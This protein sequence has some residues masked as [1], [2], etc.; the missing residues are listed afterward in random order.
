MSQAKERL[1]ILWISHLIPYPP[2]GGVLMRSNFLAT[3]LARH[4]Q[5]DLLALNQ[6]GLMGAYFPSQEEGI[7]KA[8][9]ALEPSFGRI[10]FCA[11]SVPA[12]SRAKAW[13]AG[14]SLFT[15]LPYSIACLTDPELEKAIEGRIRRQDYDVVHF[16]TI[17]LAQYRHLAGDLPTVL[18]HHNVES[19]MMLRRA[20]KEPNPVKKLYFYQE[21]YRLRRYERELAPQFDG[22]ITCSEVDSERLHELV[23]GLNIKCIPNAVRV[24]DHQPQN[25]PQPGET[26]DLLFIGG[27]DWYPNRDAVMHLAEEI[28]PRL[29]EHLEG[30]VHIIGKN[31]PA[32]LTGMAAE[33]P[34]FHIHG[35]VDDIEEV[36]RRSLI[37][38]CP[39]RDGGGTKLKVLD[40]MAHGM[41]VVGYPETFEGLEVT[42][43]QDCLLCTTPEQFSRRVLELQREPERARLIG[44][45][46]RRL[47]EEKYE[48][49]KVG[50]ALADYYRQVA[51]KQAPVRE[52]ASQL[53]Q[54]RAAANGR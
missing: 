5:V 40:A 14:K 29:A 13:L 54:W 53:A 30:D 24:A 11:S 28:M 51:A 33:F 23:Q 3:E 18:D 9:A 22:H 4:H 8:R 46:A 45:R 2:K 50:A 16:D 6:P 44:E 25:N 38:V 34:R 31:P 43:G 36:Y 21:G 39:I 7:E 49:V 12:G 52:S 20:E 15:K 42:D 17:G 32:A 26:K 19:Q 10:E 27:L 35:F 1:K 47:V 48:A 41:P 37:F